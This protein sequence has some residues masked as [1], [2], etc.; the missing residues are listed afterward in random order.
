MQ[1]HWNQNIFQP[2]YK[3][4]ENLQH[5][6]FQNKL[7][8]ACFVCMSAE[9]SDQLVNILICLFAK[10]GGRWHSGLGRLLFGNTGLRVQFPPKVEVADML[11]S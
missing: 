9:I 11:G 3:W 10:Y 6:S 2:K 5:L 7:V 4:K 1:T 8:F